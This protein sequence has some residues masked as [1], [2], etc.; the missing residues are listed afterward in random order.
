[1]G[2]SGEWGATILNMVVK[3]DLNEKMIFE[4]SLEKWRSLVTIWGMSVLGG[5]NSRDKGSSE[6]EAPWAE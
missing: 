3:V 4:D 5:R 6:S 1:M 2:V